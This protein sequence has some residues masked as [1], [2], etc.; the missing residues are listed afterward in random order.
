MLPKNESK[1]KTFS[2]L[3]SC[4]PFCV[5]PTPEASY[6]YK[7][8]TFPVASVWDTKICWPHW[9]AESGLWKEA[10]ARFALI[11]FHARPHGKGMGG[12]VWST[13]SKLE[14]GKHTSMHKHARTHTRSHS[15][16]LKWTAVRFAFVFFAQ[17][18]CCSTG[19][20]TF[21]IPPSY[22]PQA[23]A[24]RSRWCVNNRRCLCT[25]RLYK[26]ARTCRGWRVRVGFC[27]EEKGGGPSM[28]ASNSVELRSAWLSSALVAQ[29]KAVSINKHCAHFMPSPFPF[30]F[31]FPFHS[32]TQCTRAL[33][34]ALCHLVLVCYVLIP[35][36][37]L[38]LEIF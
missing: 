7:C 23:N 18:V 30:P 20:F 4:C 32:A 15:H 34:N 24:S 37:L 3:L 10:G 19:E 31:P 13:E 8:A 35:F 21:G 9:W 14:L 25:Q 17:S 28:M 2:F 38:T 11:K 22:P 5:E 16:W 33:P 6:S 26:H 36:I 12:L 27:V 1:K 29:I